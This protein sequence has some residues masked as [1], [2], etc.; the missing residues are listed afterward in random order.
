MHIF[1]TIQAINLKNEIGRIQVSN[2]EIKDVI[3]TVRVMIRVTHQMVT[4]A[5]NTAFVNINHYWMKQMPPRLENSLL[6]LLENGGMHYVFYR[7]YLPQ[8]SNTNSKECI[9]LAR[10]FFCTHCCPQAVRI[11][12]NSYCLCCQ[13]LVNAAESLLFFV[14][15]PKAPVLSATTNLKNVGSRLFPEY[16][17]TLLMKSTRKYR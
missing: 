15:K 16:G 9:S 12:Q 11:D 13:K 6:T 17:E 14:M 3:E 2:I 5:E 1:P 4:R 7:W 8:F 10:R